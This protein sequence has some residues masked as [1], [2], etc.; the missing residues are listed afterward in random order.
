MQNTDAQAT[1]KNLFE[2]KLQSVVQC[3][4]I[5]FESTRDEVFNTLQLSVKGNENIEDSIRQYVAAEMLDGDNQYEVEGHGKQDAKKF[6]RFKE[7][8]AVLQVS[9]NRFDYDFQLDR[10]AKNNQKFEFRDVLDLDSILP[11][12]SNDSSQTQ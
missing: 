8:P 6:I 3:P 5:N 12:E 4:K 1:Y 2:G 9:L 10:M 7:F 11:R